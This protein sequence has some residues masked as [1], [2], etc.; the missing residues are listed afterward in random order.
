MKLLAGEP[1]LSVNVATV[2]LKLLLTLWF[3]F[4]PDATNV[5]GMAVTLAR[6]TAVAVALVVAL[7]SVT[8]TRNGCGPAV[9]VP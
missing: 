1:S 2:P 9:D 5:G 7:V 4:R 3:R 8:L 6:L